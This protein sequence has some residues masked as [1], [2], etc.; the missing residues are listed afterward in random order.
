MNRFRSRTSKV[1]TG[2]L[3]TSLIMGSAQASDFDVDLS[4]IDM[5][6]LFDVI[7]PSQPDSDSIIEENNKDVPIVDEEPPD[8]TEIEKEGNSTIGEQGSDSGLV[9]AYPNGDIES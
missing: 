4:G 6:S 7:P 8:G 9:N 3:L 5:D 1:L 2:V